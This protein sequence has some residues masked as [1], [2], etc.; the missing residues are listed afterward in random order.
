MENDFESRFR[1]SMSAQ[2]NPVVAKPKKGLPKW[3][4]IFIVFV[5]LMLIGLVVLVVMLPNGDGGE[6]DVGDS[7]IPQQSEPP[8]MEVLNEEFAAAAA[9]GEH[10][11][12]TTEERWTAYIDLYPTSVRDNL[13][14]K[15]SDVLDPDS[16]Y[17]FVMIGALNSKALDYYLDKGYIVAMVSMRDIKTTYIIYGRSDYSYL[18]F[19]SVLPN[20]VLYM[21]RVDLF[22]GVTGVPDFYAVKGEE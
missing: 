9:G 14:L 10:A 7:D 3:L 19:N 18:V 20:E 11:D 17:K 12:Y 22:E 5:F 15:L 6:V 2:P 8:R 1:A 4:V 16:S 21:T 13:G